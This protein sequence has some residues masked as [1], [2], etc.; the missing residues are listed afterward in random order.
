MR[1]TV[2][3]PRLPPQLYVD[4][5]APTQPLEFFLGRRR[6]EMTHK[7]GYRPSKQC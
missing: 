4:I 5:R 2:S 6:E 7:P 1:E 3:R